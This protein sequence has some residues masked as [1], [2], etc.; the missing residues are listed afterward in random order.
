MDTEGLR[1]YMSKFGEL[2]DVI[3]MK[4]F[5]YCLASVVHFF[6]YAPRPR[7]VPLKGKW[8]PVI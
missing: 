5:V 1:E 3:V 2:E 7:L 8:E 6:C 4:V